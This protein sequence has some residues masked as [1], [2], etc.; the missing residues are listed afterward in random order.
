MK[1][2]VSVSLAALALAG[3]AANSTIAVAQ[4]PTSAPASVALSAADAD[5]FIAAVEKDLFAYAVESSQVNW[6]NATY[7]TE[8][9]DALAAKINAV[10]TE[11][12][13]K[14]ALEAA[15]YASLP[16]LDYDTK[17]KL[18][19]LRTG[20]I[21]P[22]PTTPG[23]ATELNEIATKLQSDYGKGKGTLNGKPISGS[24]IETEMGN[25]KRSPAEL[26]EMWVSWHDNVGAPMKADYERMV[27][28]S[29]AGAKELGFNDVGTMW[30]SS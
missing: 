5:A 15:K 23:A 13:V 4:T 10:G 18:D 9:T 27:G 24:E 7:I 30:R 28:I 1:L 8:D 20:I 17:R 2:L 3:C 19:I 16:G 6:V 22:A 11:K 12:S 21:L 26:S 25:L 29:N 14:Y